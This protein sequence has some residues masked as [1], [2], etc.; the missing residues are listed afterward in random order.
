MTPRRTVLLC[1]MLTCFFTWYRADGQGKAPGCT[2]PYYDGSYGPPGDGDVALESAAIGPDASIYFGCMNYPTYS[3]MKLDSFGNMIRSTSYTPVGANNPGSPGKTIVDAD[4]NLFSVIFNNY[5]VRTDTLGNIL[6]GAQLSFFNNNLSMSFADLAMLPN[7]DKLFLYTSSFGGSPTAFLIETSPDASVIRW[8]KYLYANTYLYLNVS[9]LVNGNSILV[10]VN[11]SGSY[12]F[13]NGSGIL[14]LDAG[15]GAVM[16]QRWFSQL[17][18]FNHISAYNTGYIFSGVTSA[19]GSSSFYLRTDT[20]L[21]VEAAYSFPSYPVNYPYG[22]PFLFQAQADGSV[23]G[24]YSGSNMTLFLIS[25]GDVIQWASGLFG[26]YQHP[27][28]ML[29]DPSGIFISTDYIANDVITGGPLSGVEL[30]KASY[31]GYFP[32]CTNPTQ[33]TMQMSAY[34]TTSVTPI[35]SF[36]DTAGVSVSAAAIQATAGPALGGSTC[37][38]TPTCSSLQVTGNPNVCMGSGTFTAVANSGCSLPLS[39][40]VTGGP[41][42]PGAPATAT[43]QPAGNDAVTVSFSQDGTYMLKALVNYNCANF[44]DSILVHVTTGSHLSLGPDTILCAGNNIKLHAGSNY[45]SYVWQDGSTD[46]TFLVTLPGT[47]SV[48]VVDH[49]GNSYSASINIPFGP[50]V[51]S[52]YPAGITKCA[53]DTLSYPLPS[54]FDSVFFLSSS[55]GA[56]IV[57]DTLQIFT[58]TASS[59]YVQTRETNGCSVDPQIAVQVYPQPPLNIGGDQTVCPGD[60]VLLDAGTSFSTYQWSTGSTNEAIWAEAKGTYDVR[61]TTPGGCIL[62]DTMILANYPAPVTHLDPDTVLCVGTDR[63]LTPGAGF[64]SY[65]WN[66]GSSAPTLTV[67]SIG[68]YRVTVTDGQGCSTTDSVD[69]VALAPLP[70][71]F[72]PADTSICQYGSVTLKP[73]GEFTSYLWSD[74]S[75]GATLTV[76]SAGLYD[77][78]VVDRNGC[79]GRDSVLLAAKECLVGFYAPNAFTPNHDGKNDQFRPLIYGNVLQYKF[80]VYNRWGQQVFASTQLM[81][82]WDGTVGGTLQPGGAYVWYCLY[83][84]EGEPVQTQKGTV[85]LIR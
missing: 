37:T 2:T 62:R 48:T 30:Y 32:P 82:G 27:I 1:L 34:A 49:C 45:S 71:K 78:Q 58:K 3:I 21:N 36:R 63:V 6:A 28:T 15:T 85:L 66:N 68:Q 39:W 81:Q 40:S 84:L 76:R 33:A 29:L 38:G 79:T 16:Q 57:N 60:S 61:A 59:Y 10:G 53:D 31:S 74:G 24:F 46:S 52:P 80:I 17:L 50:L 11:L 23:Y 44:G 9:M 67:D 47:Y 72:L 26:F 13:P 35:A 43:I 7:G 54:G 42:A 65:Q 73:D 4:G 25:P 20:S 12:Y 8:T 22:F 77:L 83:Q 14:K 56:R 75:T 41:G 5:I 55:A 70:S 18:A 64:A 69:I 19:P 51:A